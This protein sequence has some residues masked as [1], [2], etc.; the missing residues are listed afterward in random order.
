MIFLRG[1]IIIFAG[2]G[3]L[4][5]VRPTGETWGQVSSYFHNA[6]YEAT[7]ALE[8]AARPD[9]ASLL[10]MDSSPKVN[11]PKSM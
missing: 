4:C 8:E 5:W 11:H 7:L 1:M 9:L 3:L 2:A 10:S 6:P